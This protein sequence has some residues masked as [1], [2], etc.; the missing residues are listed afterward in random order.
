MTV[1]AKVCPFCGS[2][3]TVKEA[4]FATSLMV[5][6]HHCRHCNSFFEAIKW[7]D[8]G[9]ELDLPAFL[10]DDPRRTRERE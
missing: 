7:G 6:R 3:D 4:D 5:N 10:R 8:R 1:V 9:D 2:T